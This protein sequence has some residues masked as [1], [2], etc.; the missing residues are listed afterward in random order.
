MKLG[1]GNLLPLL[2]HA[3]HTCTSF[4]S[5]AAFEWRLQLLQFSKIKRTSV[6]T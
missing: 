3:Q 5:Y 4:G 6:T 1:A 2:M